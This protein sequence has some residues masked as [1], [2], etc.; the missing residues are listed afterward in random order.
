MVEAERRRVDRS[1]PNTRDADLARRSWLA[2]VLLVATAAGCGGSA[3]PAP[4]TAAPRVAAA[5][6]AHR[7]TAFVP[8]IAYTLPAGWLIADDSADYY[9]LESVV[10]DAIGIRVFRTPRAASQDAACPLGAASGVGSG[11][12]ELVDWIRALP[13]LAAGAPVAV[14][15]GGLAGWQLDLSIVPGWTSSCPF[16]NGIPTVALFVGSSDASF[17]W[18]VAGSERLRL[19]VLDVPGQGTVVVD[20]DAFDGSLMDGLLAGATPIVS[21][22]TFGLP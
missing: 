19:S 21:G 3:S 1:T 22:M 6:G 9:A 20:I 15:V 4:A 8:P 14:T 11:A 16:A 2:L 13:G 7:S 5:P 12:R 10:S 18:V 17:R